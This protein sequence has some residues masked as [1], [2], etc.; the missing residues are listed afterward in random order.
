MKSGMKSVDGSGCVGAIK[1]HK[2]QKRMDD[3]LLGVRRVTHPEAAE[4]EELGGL[5]GEGKEQEQVLNWQ[6]LYELSGGIPH[7]RVVIANGAIR[8]ADVRA[9]AKEKHVLPSNPVSLQNMAREMSHLRRENAR[10]RQENRDNA[11]QQERNQVTTDLLF[12]LHRS[13]FL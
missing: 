8:T 7:G 13:S 4:D 1:S 9:T 11:M 5:E 3:Y 12:V 10:L 6:V 2:A